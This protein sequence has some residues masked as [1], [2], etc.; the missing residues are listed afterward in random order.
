[1]LSLSNI[2]SVESAIQKIES[3]RRK[4]NFQYEE[5][6]IGITN[7]IERRYAEHNLEFDDIEIHLDVKTKN[8]VCD[9]EKHFINKGIEGHEGGPAEDTTYV[10]CYF[11]T[12]TTEQ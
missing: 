8:N 10:Y 3:W 9:V 6:Y 1:M 7:D 11:I 4:N 12:N 2:L 5:C